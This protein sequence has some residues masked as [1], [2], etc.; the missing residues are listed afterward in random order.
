M[1]ICRGV[2]IGKVFLFTLVEDSVPEF[3]VSTDDIEKE[4][5]RYRNAVE[6]GYQDIGRLKLKMEMENILEGAAILETHQQMLQD[7]I[8]NFEV[9]KQIRLTKKN[10]EYIFHK[11][12]KSYQKK[13]TLLSDPFFR[14]RFKDIQDISRRV[15]GYLLDSVRFSLADIPKNSVVFAREFSPTDIAEMN[16][17]E[18]TALVAE[19]GGATSHAAIVAKAKGIPYISNVDFSGL[20]IHS[21]ADVIVDG[22]S[23]EIILYPTPQTLLHYKMIVENLH[24]H[25]CRLVAMKELESETYDGYRIKLSANIDTVNEVEG[26]HQFGRYGVGLFRSEYVFFPNGTFPDEE[27]QFE[28]YRSMVEKMQGLPITIRTF[29]IGGDK[30]VGDRK[31]VQE[32]NPY[33][34][35]R[36]IRFMLK[37]KNI[38]K[39]QLR[40]ILRAGAYGNVSIMFPMIS[41]LTELV[42]A[43]ELVKQAQNELLSEG[44]PF[45]RGMR[46][47]CM[48]EVPSAAIISDLLAKECDF[49][50]IGTN[51][52]VQ[53]ALA[54]D[55][56]NH[57][58]SH[59][60]T[61]THP[62]VLR[63]IK[64]I[65][66]EANHR[67]IPVTVCGEIASDPRFTPLLLG[68][69]VHELSVASRYIPIIKNSIRNTSIIEACKMVEKVMALSTS[70]EI[71]SL[72]TEK[73]KDNLP[74]DCFYNC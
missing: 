47:G 23:G 56:D 6:K 13:F 25:L 12:I 55:R 28:I 22:R 4:V 21:S 41:A 17:A 61:P 35:C 62:C 33:L 45:G 8:L 40:A 39:I 11:V 37:E 7:P 30:Q 14:E 19:M 66:S 68:L 16:Q 49:L 69:G 67:G 27:E 48:I 26:L 38:F 3:F 65:V 36:A 73:Y 50:S 46:I 52:L 18:I 32:A 43:K 71:E 1:P 5:Q 54:V 74:D 42:E 51:D 64:L 44:K 53:Y 15:M 57:T 24:L 20:K 34:G 10:A 2:A 70:S 29:D 59:W 63:L 60:Y 9:E 58:L 72:L 31:A